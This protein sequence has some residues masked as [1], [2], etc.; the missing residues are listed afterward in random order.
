MSTK[1]ILILGGNGKTGRKVNQQLL[2]LGYT[3]SI[4]SRKG[5]PV[6]DWEDEGTWSAVL[7]GIDKVYLTFQPDLAIPRALETIRK[8]TDLAI[9]KGIQKIV[10]LSGRGE[11]EAQ[12]CEQIV[13][14]TAI[15]W[16]IVRCD[17]FNQNFSESFLLEPILVGHIAL[18]RAETL[19]PF[20]DT[21]DIAEIVVASLTSNQHKHKLYELTGPRLLTF[22]QAIQE[23]A[24]ETERTLVFEGVSIDAYI[25]M[26]KEYQLPEDYIWLVT[27]LFTHVLD[28]KNSNTTNDIEK[29][30][31]RKAKDFT[32]YVKETAATGIWNPEK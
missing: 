31:G 11:E 6:F 14:N 3:T 12:R 4:G 10:L 30:L 18:P 15:N 32:Q 24:K 17:W 8:I 29:V 27:Y 1:K 23:I 20:V 9:K 13:M 5:S 21:D 22:A 19:I 28:G 2:A 16:T 26:M 25:E 7:E